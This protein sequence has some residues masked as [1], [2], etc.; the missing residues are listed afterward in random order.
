MNRMRSGMRND[1]WGRE[2]NELFAFRI[3]IASPTPSQ[4]YKLFIRSSKQPPIGTPGDRRRDGRMLAE[5]GRE[6]K[7][8]RNASRGAAAEAGAMRRLLADPLLFARTGDRGRSRRIA[9]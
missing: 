5:V 7:D 8:I 2:A 6:P 3:R 9:A 1:T 4:D